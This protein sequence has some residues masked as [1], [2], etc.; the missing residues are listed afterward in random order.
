MRR[1]QFLATGTALLGVAVAGC[2]HPDVVLDFEAAS[3]EDVADEVSVAPEPAS[4]EHAVVTSAIENGSTTRTGRR[5]LFDD[6]STVRIEDRYYEVEETRLSTDET[7]VYAVRI[8]F[9]PP[10]TTPELGAIDYVDL[11][12]TDRDRLESLVTDE[13]PPTGEGYDLGASYGTADEVG[14]D[15]V[16]VP[17]QQYDIIVHEGDRYRIDVE[18]RVT[19]EAKYRY[20]ASE[21]A[22]GVSAFAD[23]VRERYLFTLSSLSDAEREVVQEAIDDGYFEDTD[24][25][26]SVV[27]RLQQHEGIEVAEF[28]GTWLLAYQ[29]GEYLAYAEW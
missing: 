16:F 4:E 28:Y 27:D 25:F 9:D 24:A 5:E 19:E 3:D 6:T 26:R 14:E 18:S 11:P 15:S 22:D 12:A 7:T 2:A 8:D 21:A 29:G 13:D 17:D 1:R 10:D 23:Q 20:E